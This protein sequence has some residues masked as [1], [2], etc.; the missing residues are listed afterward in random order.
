MSNS[1]PL[2]PAL[3]EPPALGPIVR[4]A[5]KANGLTLDQVAARTGLSKS[6][7]SQIERGIVNPT[8]AVVW[9]L[10]QALGLELSALD[11]DTSPESR[12][13]EHLHHY[14]TPEKRS[15]D[16]KV[17]LRLLSPQRTILPAEWY[18][19]QLQPGGILRA[20]PHAVGTYEHLSCLEGVLT[21][22]IG[23]RSVTLPAGD[24]LRYDADQPHSI[25]NGHN[26]PSRALLVVALPAQYKG[27][28]ILT[29]EA[30]SRGS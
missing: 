3:N 2:T 26:A 28:R 19:M 13:I 20:P 24:T 18:D 30:Q 12:V 17:V 21:V 1:A 11:P 25:A 22:T 8:F 16:G 7:V 29:D 15:A 14:A 10:T 27:Q 6:L 23:S 5:R 9:R 4:R